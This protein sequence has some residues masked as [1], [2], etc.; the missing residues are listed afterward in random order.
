[1]LVTSTVPLVVWGFSECYLRFS[2]QVFSLEA[3]ALADRMVHLCNYSVQ[4]DA[5]VGS[6]DVERATGSGQTDDIDDKRVVG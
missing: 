5:P 1:M 6:G 4:K 2:S 3:D